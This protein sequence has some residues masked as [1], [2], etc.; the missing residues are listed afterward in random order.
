MWKLPDL[1]RGDRVEVRSR[2]EILA[3]LDATGAL[4]GMPFMPEM[5]QFCGR[6]LRV[7]AVAHKTCDT[8]TRSGGRK[9]DRMVHLEGARCDGSAHG[10]CEADCNLFWREEWLKRVP[11]EGFARASQLAETPATPS[12][13]TPEV[14]RAATYAADSNADSPQY[15]CQATRLLG[16]SRPLA[17]WNLRQYWHDVST[18]NYRLA[19]ALTVLTLAAVSWLLRLPFGYRAFRAAY[20]WL[21][22][23]LTGRPAPQIAGLIPDGA[24]TPVASL[25]LTP[26]QRVRVRPA[27]EIAATLNRSNKNRGM[28]FDTEETPYCGQTFLVRRHVTRIID[29]RSGRMVPMRTP[30]VT[31]EGVV[32]R[33]HYSAGRMLCPRAIPSYWRDVWLEPV[34][35]GER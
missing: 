34:D 31:L 7:A 17:W 32:C 18:G 28:G 25:R 9:L 26:G 22:R 14:L 23:R 3:T 2:E 20:R 12:Q 29:E 16:A 27:A 8:A 1:K 24:P 5:L 11:A 13:S 19:Q 35:P 15:S 30:C 4:A 10:G 21:H 33:A 6:Q